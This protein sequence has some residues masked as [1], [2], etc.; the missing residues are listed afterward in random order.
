MFEVEIKYRVSLLDDL[1]KIVSLMAKPIG[2]SVEEDHYFNHPCRDFAQSDEAIRIRIHGDG[3]VIMTYKGRRI[4][5][6]GKS[7]MEINLKVDD[8]D[9]AALMMA[10]LG[11]KEVAVIRK[12]RELFTVDK[13]TI[14]LDNADNLGKFVEVETMVSDESLIDE[15]AQD[16][17]KFAQ[18]KLGLKPEQIERRTYLELAMQ[19]PSQ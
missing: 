13:Y 19:A 10:S 5:S 18:E 11:F 8:Y 16:I 15:A 4:G 12:R 9:N 2:I 17:L 14:Y 6:V 7:R 1:R 3:E